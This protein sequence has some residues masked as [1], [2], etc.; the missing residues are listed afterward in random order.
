M[1][2]A[3]L[4]EHPTAARQRRLDAMRVGMPLPSVLC[5]TCGRYCDY[6]FPLEHVD[7]NVVAAHRE[8]CEHCCPKERIA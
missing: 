7:G 1:T 2:A 6:T 5:W 8:P 3:K 4:I